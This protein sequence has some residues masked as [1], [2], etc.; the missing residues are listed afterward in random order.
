M[1]YAIL[2]CSRAA[3]EESST[4]ASRRT[5]HG[6][7]NIRTKSRHATKRNYTMRRH[8]PPAMLCL[9]MVAMGDGLA[10]TENHCHAPAVNAD[11]ERLAIRYEGDT[12]ILYLY[13]LRQQICAAIDAGTI[14]LEHGMQRFE[15]ERQRV[16]ENK[17]ERLKDSDPP[18]AL[19]GI[20]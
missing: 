1:R 11:W 6:P 19:G 7:T 17:R 4:V 15:V 20:G 13:Q 3:G 2:R 8:L 9:A 14:T 12:G 5:P 10:G 18:A 16:I